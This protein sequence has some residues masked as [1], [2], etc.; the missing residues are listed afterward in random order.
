MVA[1]P[2]VAA[3]PGRVVPLLSVITTLSALSVMLDGALPN[4]SRTVAMPPLPGAMA[5]IDME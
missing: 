3:A 2:S 1:L 5:S 4:F